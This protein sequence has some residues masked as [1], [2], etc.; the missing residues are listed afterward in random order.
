MNWK[1][2]SLFGLIFT[3][4]L[5][6][7]I[8]IGVAIY[9]DK[10]AIDVLTIVFPFTDLMFWVYSIPIILLYSLL[11]DMDHKNSKITSLFYLT[12]FIIILISYLTNRYL[13]IKTL[14]DF[15]GAMLY[16]IILIISTYIISTY[17]KHRGITHTLWFGLLSTGLLM[18]VGIDYI[19]YYIVAFLGF[20]SHMVA[21]LIPFKWT[22]KPK[23]T[24]FKI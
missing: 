23:F 8:N 10:M 21:D 16:G 17:F 14:Y 3:I 11:P 4:I 2:H 19:I 7:F 22:S 13:E 20:W 1:H 18:L 9:Q 12:G 24:Q 6:L 5:M 15:G